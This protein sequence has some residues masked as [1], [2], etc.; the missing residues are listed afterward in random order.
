M[1]TDESWLASLSREI[2]TTGNASATEPF[3]DL[4]HRTPHAVR[5]L[6]HAT[7]GLFIASTGF[8]LGVVRTLSLL[9][10][11]ICLYLFYCIAKNYRLPGLS[12]VILL[13]MDMQFIYSA[14][15]G[16]QEIVIL[17]LM[18]ISVYL[19]AKDS[20]S[21]FRKGLTVAIPIAVSFFI[22]PY[23]ALAALPPGL[24]ILTELIQ[25]KRRAFELAGYAMVLGTAAAAVIGLSLLMNFGFIS[26]YPRYGASEG[27]TDTLSVKLLGFDDFYRKLFKRISGTYYIPEIR[28]LFMTGATAFVTGLLCGKLRRSRLYR[29]SLIGLAVINIG[30]I[31]IGKYS[32]VSV[33]FTLPFLVL[34]ISG[35]LGCLKGIYL[36][37][38]TGLLIVF[39]AFNSIYTIATDIIAEKETYR[40]FCGNISS[41]IEP[42]TSVLG[43]LQL[44]F[45]L[46]ENQLY[47]WRNLEHL[48]KAAID[49]SVYIEE[50]NIR[51]IFMTDEID[52]LYDSRPVW[53]IMYGNPS[54]WYPELQDFISRNCILITK[55]ESPGYAERLVH[56]RNGKGSFRIYKVNTD[57]FINR[58]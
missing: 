28:L 55:L 7:Q 52:Y 41:T 50:N 4:M 56:R 30:I 20:S 42:G 3:F 51:Y 19:V 36:K 39:F 17:L 45:C 54:G 21:S 38:V 13:S 22:H 2:I 43:G 8:S 10:A 5:L 25:G 14:H 9:S 44:L 6:F 1:H 34:L 46:P 57:Y 49:I 53:N 24:I 29:D 32:P 47:D 48:D 27:V 40:E 23:G 18:L 12:A 11:S 33:I 16:R 37:A 31:L 15:M 26:D 35:A 58:E